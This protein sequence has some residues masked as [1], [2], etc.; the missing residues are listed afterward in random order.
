[1]PDV[2]VPVYALPSSS[3]M[4]ERLE[5]RRIT[6][7]RAMPPEA[8]L[9]LR[10]VD[11][12]FPTQGWGGETGIAV[13]RTPPSC[14]LAVHESKAIAGYLCFD[15]TFRGFIGPGGVS[16]AYRRAG[17][18]T[19]LMLRACQAMHELGYAYAIVGDPADATLA[20]LEKLGGA[21]VPLSGP[22]PYAGMLPL[23]DPRSS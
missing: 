2:I 5:H 16:P 21:A 1:M 23:S 17:V 18:F 11:Q 20:L 14:L 22:G 13:S 15:V 7:R 9:V 8:P 10:W 3:E 12:H 4:L 6:I 19:A